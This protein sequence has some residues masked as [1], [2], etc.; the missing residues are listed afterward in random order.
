MGINNAS[1]NKEL[2]AEFIN[3]VLSEE[4]QTVYFLDEG[5][6][7]NQKSAQQ[8]QNT[9][10]EFTAGFLSPGSTEV[11]HITYPNQEERNQLFGYISNLKTPVYQDDILL[12][13]IISEAGDYFEGVESVEKTAEKIINN[14]KLY[15]E[16]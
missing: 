7:I 12:E 10:E 5:F 6:P 11:V 3:E 1:T 16:E 4:I 9:D 13:M 15:M 2:A 8:W 14:A